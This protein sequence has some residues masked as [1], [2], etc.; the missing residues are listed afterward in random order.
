M[1]ELWG[2]PYAASGLRDV[3]KVQGTSGRRC[4]PPRA[5]EREESQ[6]DRIQLTGGKISGGFPLAFLW[7][8]GTFHAL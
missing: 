2:F 6:R 8:T 3:R 4:N 5:K 1:R 7:R